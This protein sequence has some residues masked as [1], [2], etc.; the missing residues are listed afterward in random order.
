MQC[1]GGQIKGDPGMATDLLAPIAAPSAAWLISRCSRIIATRRP[2]I[3]SLALCLSIAVVSK[4]E[5][6]GRLI[7][8]TRDSFPGSGPQDA[9]LGAADLAADRLSETRP[10]PSASARVLPPMPAG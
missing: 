4:L 9:V 5:N 7:E 6:A 8:R 10:G 3:A 1:G 2:M